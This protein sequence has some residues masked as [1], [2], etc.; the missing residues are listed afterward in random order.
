MAILV[1]GSS[2]SP[3]AAPRLASWFVSVSFA[4]VYVLETLAFRPDS[5]IR[6]TCSGFWW[7]GLC[8]GVPS[9]SFSLSPARLLCPLRLGL[10]E[11]QDPPLP[12]A[13]C[14]PEP[15]LPLNLFS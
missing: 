2:P 3:A 1:T 5:G 8:C 11:P 13:P 14:I 15:F 10:G 12:P 6:V 4:C 9:V 7:S